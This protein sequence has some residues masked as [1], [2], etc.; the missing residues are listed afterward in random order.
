MAA[1]F[2]QER[3]IPDSLSIFSSPV[4][5]RKKMNPVLVP[6]LLASAW[7]FLTSRLPI[8]TLLD[9]NLADIAL[10]IRKKTCAANASY[11]DFL[12]G[13]IDSVSNPSLLMP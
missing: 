3:P 7:W 1:T 13:M 11:T 6:N 5:A 4:N 12:I 10:V 8:N 9:D 2:V